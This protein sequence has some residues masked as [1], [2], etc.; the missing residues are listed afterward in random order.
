M[1]SDYINGA[2]LGYE[3]EP[4]EACQQTRTSHAGHTNQM[5]S[6][7]LEVTKEKQGKEDEERVINK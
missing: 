1:R 7:E 5:A 3:G 2:H 4:W 6:A